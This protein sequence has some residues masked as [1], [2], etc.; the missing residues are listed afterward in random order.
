M[1]GFNEGGTGH[2]PQVKSNENPVEEIS[3][4]NWNKI[5]SEINKGLDAIDELKNNPE[6]K[7]EINQI[8]NTMGTLLKQLR[9]LE[10]KLGIKQDFS[11]S[12]EEAA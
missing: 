5:R 6:A 12:E 8:W 10:E 7:E 9:E 3:M 2:A 4:E 1:A 11:V